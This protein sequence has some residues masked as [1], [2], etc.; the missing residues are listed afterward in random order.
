M[1]TLHARIFSI[2]WLVIFAVITTAGFIRWGPETVRTDI[3]DL[4]PKQALETRAGTVLSHIAK[5]S[6]QDVWILVLHPD[7]TQAKKAVDQIR[8]SLETAG[9]KP[10]DPAAGLDPAAV[11]RALF[12]YREN[13]LTD[14]DRAWLESADD[15]ALLARAMRILYRPLAPNS[16]RAVDDPLGLFENWIASQ[17]SVDRFTIVDGRTAVLDDEKHLWFILQLKSESA[18]SAVDGQKLRRDR[19]SGQFRGNLYRYDLRFGHC[20]TRLGV[21]C[22]TRPFDANTCSSRHIHR[23]CRCLRGCSLRR[24]SCNHDCFRSDAAGHLRRLRV[25]LAM[26]SLKQHRGT[27]CQRAPIPAASSLVAVD[28]RKLS[29]HAHHADA[30]TAS[31]QRLLHCWAHLYLCRRHALDGPLCSSHEPLSLFESFCKL[32]FKTACFAHDSVKNRAFD[33]YFRRGSQRSCS[34]FHHERTSIDQRRRQRTSF[35]TSCTQR[36]SESGKPCSIFCC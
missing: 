18:V 17:S 4:L 30:R 33:I 28:H 24:N 12:P 1:T 5:S 36:D 8:R 15:K 31:S 14:K 13:F 22:S 16:W 3:E 20:R 23:F 11:H 9:F 2:L 25:S 27:L 32:F 7:R 19:A 35:K 6:A 10:F 26:R 21:F 34:T 29:D